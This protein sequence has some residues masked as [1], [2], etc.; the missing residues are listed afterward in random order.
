MR[1]RRPQPSCFS[2]VMNLVGVGQRGV[3]MACFLE[4]EK[5]SVPTLHRGEQSGTRF[6]MPTRGGRLLVPGTSDGHDIIKGGLLHSALDGISLAS[7][8]N[9]P[10]FARFY[11]QGDLGQQDRREI[12]GRAYFTWPLPLLQQHA[13]TTGTLHPTVI[14]PQLW[15]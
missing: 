11:L 2:R 14:T 10:I 5:S 3:G 8:P 7:H 13:A 1:Q 15:V 12:C 9:K 4:R 6:A